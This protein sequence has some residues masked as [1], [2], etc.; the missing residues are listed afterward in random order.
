M[1][2]VRAFLLRLHW[3]RPLVKNSNFG[4]IPRVGYVE[5]ARTGTDRPFLFNEPSAM[6]NS[7]W[8]VRIDELRKRLVP[9]RGGL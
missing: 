5:F 4:R 2:P 7:Q 9:L 1:V 8:Q 3:E 6:T